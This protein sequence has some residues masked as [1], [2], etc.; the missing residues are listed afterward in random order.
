MGSLGPTGQWPWGWP[1]VGHIG[2]A[3]VQPSATLQRRQRAGVGRKKATEG[4]QAGGLDLRVRAGV[5]HAMVTTAGAGDGR[6]IADVEVCGCRSW[7]RMESV[8]G[9]TNGGTG[10]LFRTR[11]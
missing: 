4:L 1:P 5:A 10:G 3:A 7:A 8:T 9:G 2:A 11:G 6:S